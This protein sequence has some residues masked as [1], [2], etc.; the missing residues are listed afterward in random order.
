M[1]ALRRASSALF[2]P[3]R[4]MLPRFYSEAKTPDSQRQSG[5]KLWTVAEMQKH[6]VGLLKESERE[7]YLC[8]LFLPNTVGQKVWGI[9]AFNVE[10]SRVAGSTS[11]KISEKMRYIWW[12]ETLDQVY[13]NEPPDQPVAR[14]L[15]K[16][17]HEDKVKLNRLWMERLIEYRERYDSGHVY[18]GLSDI[19]D[20]AEGTHSTVLYLTLQAMG[21]N[22]VNA[23]HAASHI[24]KALGII[25]VLR[26]APQQGQ[27]RKV[28][29]PT[30]LCI[31]H[32]VSQEAIFRQQFDQRMGDLFYE[33]ANQANSHILK[34]RSM[35]DQI[36][37]Q[38]YKALLPAIAA[39]SYLER[40]QKVDFNIFDQ[41]LQGP[42]R[43]ALPFNVLSKNWKS[44]F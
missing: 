32:A 15:A 39:S 7:M 21:V 27:H 30:Q 22:D 18:H 6:C 44:E 28:T 37:G 25:S 31:K 29:F 10:I 43:L 42:N 3:T 19:E 12:K 8:T 5:S 23:D 36:K 35:K 9:R 17:I 2:V 24:G 16:I 20:F 34:A 26:S 13:R 1:N 33:M 40:L 14:Y 4:S 38:A 41:S 11:Q